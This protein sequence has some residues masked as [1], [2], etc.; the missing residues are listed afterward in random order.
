[1]NIRDVVAPHCRHL[2][3]QCWQELVANGQVRDQQ[4]EFLRRNGSTF[5]GVLNSVVVR[6][7]QGRFLSARCLLFD[8]TNRLAK[9]KHIAD[10]NVEL[11]RRAIAAEAADRAKSQFLAAMSHEVRTPLNA[12]M[13]FT[14]LLKMRAAAPDQQDKLEKITDASEHLLEILDDVLEVARIDSKGAFVLENADFDFDAL[15]RRVV[16]SI[17]DKARA[18]GLAFHLEMGPAPRVLHGDATHLGELLRQILNNAVKFTGQG[19]ILMRGRVVE[20]RQGHVLLR[21]E[22]QDTGIGIASQD[23]ERI[24]KSFEQVDNSSTRRYGGTGL[25]LTIARKLAQLMG[26]EV[27]VRSAP[28]VGS[29]F[30]VTARLD[31]S[32]AGEAVIETSYSPVGDAKAALQRDFAGARI[33]VVEDN[34]S[35]Q[36]VMAELL[37]EVNL[38]HDMAED[39][40]IAVD[41]ARERAYPLIIMDVKMPRSDGLEA[42]RQ[43]RRLPGYETTPILAVT[44]NALNEDREQCLQAGMSDYLAKPLDPNLIFS[45]LLKWLSAKRLASW[46]P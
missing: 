7:E 29:V 30:W 1:M 39:G 24:F 12:I 26:G 40:L 33:L 9:E 46:P 18:K 34:S 17:A 4:Y 6:D 10:L 42:T 37:D 3:E 28:S 5:P 27:G 8:D 36:A 21:F 25:G 35:N 31:K 13:G 45:T 11:E 23:L 15:L 19:S 44:A 38:Q 2:I 16:E 22:V 14:Q 43:I 20:E 32:A 41:K